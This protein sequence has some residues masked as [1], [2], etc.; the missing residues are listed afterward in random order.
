MA[1][2]AGLCERCVS[3]ARRLAAIDVRGS[4]PRSDASKEHLG[5]GRAGGG[6][7]TITMRRAKEE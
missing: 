2:V 6:V 7:P 5:L 1:S 3:E 4:A